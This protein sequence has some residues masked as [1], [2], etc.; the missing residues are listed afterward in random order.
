MTFIDIFEIFIITYSIIILL[1][2]TVLTILAWHN[3]YVSKRKYTDLDLV[4]LKNSPLAPGISIVA[5]AYNEEKT[6]ISNVNSLLSLNYPNYEVVIVNDGSKDK[7]LDLLIE[8]YQLEE[9]PYSFVIKIPSKPI[10]RIF[11]STNPLYNKLTIVDKENGG[12]KA[13]AVNAGINICK[14]PYLLNTDVDC[15]LAKDALLMMILPVLKSSVR[16]I[17]IGATLRMLNNCDIENGEIVRVRPPKTFFPLVQEVEYLRSYLV[18]KMGWSVI[19]S[20]PN[21]SGGLGLFDIEILINA[22]GYDP[23]S[24]AEDMDI[25]TRMVAYMRDINRDFRIIQI[26]DTCCWTEGPPNFKIMQKQRTRW[27]RGLF[28]FFVVHRKYLLNRRYGRLGMITMPY[29]FFYEFIAPIIEFVGILVTLY[30]IFVVGIKFNILS[31]LGVFFAIYIFGLTISI[32]SI[33]MDFLKKQHYKKLR[34]YFR[35]IGITLVEVFLYH[36][37]IVFFSL[38]G[39]FDF[40]SKKNFTWGE[41]T[42]QGVN[43]KTQTIKIDN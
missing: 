37:L 12:T 14:Y 4:T 27:A 42:R 39:Y 7:T 36:P 17:G 25:T 28:Q 30:L 3:F 43:K 26:P 38:R 34:E 22:G 8:E 35:L 41:M 1:N 9:V 2:Y 11:K 13:D 16:V 23:E 33:L 21:I 29:M 40:L 31:F 18:G 20:I 6:I 19:N 24:F 32:T 5:P 15:V 10:K